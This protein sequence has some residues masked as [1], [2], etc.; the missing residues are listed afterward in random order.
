MVDKPDTFERV[1]ELEK[2]GYKYD[3]SLGAG[4]FITPG[5]NDPHFISMTKNEEVIKLVFEKQEWDKVKKYY[6]I[7]LPFEERFG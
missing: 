1:L 4:K 5:F 3:P 6:K 2:A 7:D